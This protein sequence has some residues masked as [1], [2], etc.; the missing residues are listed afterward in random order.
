MNTSVIVNI[1]ETAC[2]VYISK[3]RWF[4]SFDMDTEL[5]LNHFSAQAI[6]YSVAQ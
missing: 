2:V 6:L 4:L 5:Y 3:L 1:G